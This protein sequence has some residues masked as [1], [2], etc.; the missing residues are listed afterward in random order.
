MNITIKWLTLTDSEFVTRL[1]QIEGWVIDNYESENIIK[2]NQ[3]FCFGAF[4]DS[5]LV[6]A[7]MGFIHEK[8]SYIA[9][10]LVSHEYRNQKIG[11]RLFETLFNA[12]K[13]EKDTIYL[14]A[15]SNMKDF[16]EK[17]GFEVLSDIVRFESTTTPNFKFSP[18]MVKDLEL[19]SFKTTL[20]KMSNQ[21]FNERR[22]NLYSFLCSH[23][24]SLNFC[25][26]NAIMHSR[27]FNSKI[28]LAPFFVKSG[29]YFDAEKM[30]RAL[31]FVRNG[32]KI[33]ADVPL[34]N[35]DSVNLFIQYGFKESVGGYFMR[36]GKDLNINF[37]NI[38]SFATPCSV[39]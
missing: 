31:L 37:N 13:L 35:S 32:K 18:N 17:F 38:Y 15:A 29:A 36:Y 6:G 20:L 3:I 14:Y 24:S 5:R 10:F 4:H 16:Y 7:I 28:Q 26:P 23:A 2:Q 21:I 9:N 25:S 30:F 11:R 19:P 39:G 27:A 12:L 1:G 33:Y 34:V 8:S 22:D